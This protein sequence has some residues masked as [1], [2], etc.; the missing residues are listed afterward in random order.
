MPR[1]GRGS[2]GWIYPASHLLKADIRPFFQDLIPL[3]EDYKSAFHGFEYRLG[4]IQENVGDGRR[5]LCAL[6][7]EYVGENGWSWEDRDVP[8][9][10]NALRKAAERSRDWPWTDYLGGD[11]DQAL[12]SHREVLKHYRGRW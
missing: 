2:T 6:S 11:L 1:W 7:G 10:E 9:V 8:L 5:G 12:V 4:L 3:D